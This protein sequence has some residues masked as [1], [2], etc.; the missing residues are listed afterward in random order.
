MNDQGT[1]L[2]YHNKKQSDI[3]LLDWLLLYHSS[4]TPWLSSGYFFTTSELPWVWLSVSIIKPQK[5]VGVVVPFWHFVGLYIERGYNLGG[6]WVK[7]LF[8]IDLR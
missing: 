5:T 3:I 7:T 8:G 4:T 1:E 6:Y 2:K